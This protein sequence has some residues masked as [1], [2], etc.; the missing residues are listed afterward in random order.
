MGN[1]CLSGRQFAQIAQGSAVN[2]VV[3]TGI[4]TGMRYGINYLQNRSAQKKQQPPPQPPPQP[5]PQNPA[6]QYFNQDPQ[7]NDSYQ[8]GYGSGY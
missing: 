4:N 7:G 5:Q 8:S 6:P 2:A 3:F 1:D